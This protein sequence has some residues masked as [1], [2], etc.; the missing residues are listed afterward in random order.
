[1]VG[2][3]G[4]DPG[5]HLPGPT[6][7][8]ELRCDGATEP[9][10]GYRHVQYLE[11]LAITG[12]WV[13]AGAPQQTLLFRN[14]TRKSHSPPV[15]SFFHRHRGS[16]LAHFTNLPS[17]RAETKLVAPISYVLSVPT[18]I[19]SSVS[20]SFSIKRGNETTRPHFTLWRR[21]TTRHARNGLPAELL[22]LPRSCQSASPAAE[23]VCFALIAL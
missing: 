3:P 13:P 5:S 2:A 8:P 16:R 21:Y 1:M 20:H 17:T 12:G 14:L 10:C 15:F 9:G 7:R 11:G 22:A 4:R 23:S 6:L 19:R 18:L